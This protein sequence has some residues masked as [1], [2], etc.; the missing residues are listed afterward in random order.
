MMEDPTTNSF[1][2]WMAQLTGHEEALLTCSG[3]M[4]NQVALRTALTT[5]PYSILAD[6]RAHVF[7]MEGGGAATVCSAHIQAVTPS[8]G[9]H[10]TLDDVKQYA[11]VDADICKFGNKLGMLSY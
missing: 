7:N 11:V 10:L 8:N 5:A 2:A 4:G 1:Q 6:Y 3:T 9:H